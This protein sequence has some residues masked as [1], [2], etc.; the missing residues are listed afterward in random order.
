M[1][2]KAV[3]IGEFFA[4]E[5]VAQQFIVAGAEEDGVVRDGVPCAVGAEIPDEQAHG[6]FGAGDALVRPAFA[7]L[8]GEEMFVGEAGAGIG[9]DDVGFNCF[10]GFKANSCGFAVFM[11]CTSAPV[12]PVG[13]CTPNFR[14]RCT[15]R[16]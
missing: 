3:V 16:Q 9:D 12:P 7:G 5:N 15:M 10:A 4:V 8:A 1:Q 13:K 11:P 14:S 2:I 6:V